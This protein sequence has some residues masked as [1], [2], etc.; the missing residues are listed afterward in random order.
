M[1]WMVFST[2]SRPRFSFVCCGPLDDRMQ[3]LRPM[4]AASSHSPMRYA[5]PGPVCVKKIISIIIGLASP[6]DNAVTA[7]RRRPTRITACVCLAL[8]H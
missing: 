4:R 2:I 7:F 3:S 5:M 6:H 1:S 8:S